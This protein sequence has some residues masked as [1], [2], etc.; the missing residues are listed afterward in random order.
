MDKRRIYELKDYNLDNNRLLLNET[1]FYNA[2]GYIGVRYCFEEGYPERYKSIPGQYING[3]Y[4]ITAMNQAEG[5]YGLVKEKQVMLNISDTK[6]I[7]FFFDGEEFSM[8]EGTVLESKLQVDMNKGVTIRF[9]WWRSPNGKSLRLK[10]HE[11]HLFISFRCLP[12][13]MR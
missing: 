12:L 9:V 5:L 3:F 8:F 6:T 13:T 1:L 2:N 4:D 11:W 10:S 7:R